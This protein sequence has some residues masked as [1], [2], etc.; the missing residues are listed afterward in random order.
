MSYERRWSRLIVTLLAALALTGLAGLVYAANQGVDGLI[1]GCA[2]K[3]RGQLR[4]VATN[5][6]CKSNERR[7]TWNERGPRGRRGPQGVRGPQG[8]Q[9]PA[10]AAGAPGDRGV[11]GTTGPPGEQG[12]PGPSAYIVLSAGT[13]A[14]IQAAIDGLP[15]AGGAV[16]VSAGTYLCT[17]PIVIDRSHVTLRGVGPATVLRL[18]DHT[19]RP[20]LVLGQVTRPPLDMRSHIT[21][22]ELSIDGNESQQDFECSRGLCTP[23]DFLRNNG[24]S[25]RTVEDALV[26]DVEVR[27]ARSGGL[28]VELGSRR[29]TIRDFT[30]SHN[31]LDGLAGYDTT[32]S[33]FAGLHLHHNGAAGLS[34]D[35][36]FVGNTISQAVIADSADVGIFMRDA[37]DNIF[38]AVRVRDSASF[39]MFLAFNPEMGGGPASGN[40]F[41]GMTIARSG[42]PGDRRFGMAVSDETCA[43]GMPSSCA[44]KDNLVFG[45]QFIDNE[46]DPADDD[47]IDEEIPGCCV[48]TDPIVTR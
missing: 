48:R 42:P 20:V 11:P 31:E 40:T 43:P 45:A 19:N 28:V 32:D 29:V 10:G 15:P 5:E 47:S 12:P 7:L 23:V 4:V 17:G 37:R 39:G 9:G 21:V 24:I 6:P 34:F 27:S 1:T 41:T 26:E 18:A 2:K 36:D 14:D 3:A 13:C 44:N 46:R 30:S 16:L 38:S 8:L 25:V 35:G 33:L 22:A